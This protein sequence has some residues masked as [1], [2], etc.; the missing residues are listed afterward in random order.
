M[1]SLDCRVI[2]A[3]SAVFCDAWA[4]LCI[5]PSLGPRVSSRDSVADN[6]CAICDC[7]SATFVSPPVSFLVV[8]SAFASSCISGRANCPDI[9]ATR[10]AYFSLNCCPRFA[11]ASPADCARLISVWVR[12]RAAICGRACVWASNP[13]SSPTIIVSPICDINPSTPPCIPPLIHV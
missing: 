7:D 10:A 9:A 8:S 6:C 5:G 3:A 13:S 1:R 2:S 12:A 4:T 11:P